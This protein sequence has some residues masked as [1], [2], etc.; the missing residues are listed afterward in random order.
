MARLHERKN[1]GRSPG[2]AGVVT[3]NPDDHRESQ[4]DSD[5]TVANDAAL[6][7]PFYLGMVRVALTL[8]WVSAVVVAAGTLLPHLHHGHML[9]GPILVLAVAAAAGNSVLALMPWRRW[10]GT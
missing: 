5:L 9:H 4:D 2:A 6:L 8:G 10:L 3:G 1:A 7:E